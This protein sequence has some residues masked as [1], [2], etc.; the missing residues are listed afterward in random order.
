[1]EEAEDTIDL[2][3]ALLQV[4]S[5]ELKRNLHCFFDSNYLVAQWS[6]EP[7]VLRC[8]FRTYSLHPAKA[9]GPVELRRKASFEVVDAVDVVYKNGLLVSA[10]DIGDL[11]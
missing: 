1:M 3:S 4:P 10:S 11:T 6:D 9:G 2:R 7:A 5:L 8:G